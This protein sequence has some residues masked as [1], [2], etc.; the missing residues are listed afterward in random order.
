MSDLVMA[1]YT[2]RGDAEALRVC[3]DN[4]LEHVVA[5]SPARPIMHVAWA[6]AAGFHVVDV[7]SNEQVCR[8]MTDNPEFQQK[9]VEFGLGGAEIDIVPVHNLGWPTSATPLYR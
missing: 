7:W 6:S 2:W 1:S 4:I 8:A 9:L 5:I 3:Y